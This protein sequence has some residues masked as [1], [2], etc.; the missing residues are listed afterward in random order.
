MKEMTAMIC[1]CDKCLFTFF[2]NSLPETCPDCGSPSV[3]EATPEEKDWYYDLQQE[4]K[5]NPLLLDKVS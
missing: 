1:T 4:K 5:N 3:R 2:Y